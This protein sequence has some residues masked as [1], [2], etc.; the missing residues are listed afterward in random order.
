[1]SSQLTTPGIVHNV[2]APLQTQ[3]WATRIWHYGWGPIFI[4]AMAMA[5]TYPGRTHGL[6][7][8]TEP[9]LSDLRLATPEGRVFFA[10][11][12]FWGTLLGAF[13]CLPVGWLFDRFASRWILAGNLILLGL[14]V[15]AMAAAHTWQA[16]FVSLIL[17]RG[18][19]QSA[20]S[21]VS[22]TIV[23]KALTGP[24]LGMAMAWYAILAVPF[25]IILIMAV[26]W[27][28]TDIGLDW[29]V[30]WGGVGVSLMSL[31]VLA[32][33]LPSRVTSRSSIDS[34]SETSSEPTEITGST[35]A[36]ALRTPAFWVFS[37]T[38]SI[39][40]MIYAGVALFN[41][42]IFKERGFDDKLYFNV[43]SLVTIVALLSQ[44]VFGWLVNHVPL[45]RLLAVCLLV[46]SIS[47]VGLPNATQVWH[48]YAYGVAL[49]IASGAVS[50]LFFATWGKLYGRRALGRIQSVAQMFTV[51]GSASGPLI[52]STSKQFSSSYTSIFL[53][54][55]ALML[56]MA[57]IAWITPMPISQ[58]SREAQS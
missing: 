14:A 32:A 23:A 51:L 17:T 16:L 24:R 50:I 48:A 27:S 34:R 21:V 49:G 28:L 37:L 35:L 36:E 10:S 40:G 30:V 2:D 22:L 47:L 4:G 43:L 56:M 44:F 1:M 29:R 15:L 54:M 8:V 53:C 9:L 3:S 6:G 42:D 55:A 12:N 45:T 19:G 7:M 31:S 58:S 33:C 11:L 20:L 18:L 26:G 41:V 46:T 57:F 38:I 13:F 39:W 5:A 25:H 52:F